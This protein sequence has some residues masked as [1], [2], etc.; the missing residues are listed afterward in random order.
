MSV[1]GQSIGSGIWH[2]LPMGY[3]HIL[4][5]L[6]LFFLKSE[7]RSALVQCSVFTA[8][9]SLTLGLAALGWISVA[10]VVVESAIAMS[11]V[12][13]AVEN[14]MGA[15][16]SP[17]RLLMVFVFGLFHGLGF[18]SAMKDSLQTQSEFL[19]RLFG[20]NL[21][22][23]LAQVIIILICALIVLPT[24]AQKTWYRSVIVRP[25]SLAIAVFATF[26]TVQRLLA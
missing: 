20:F 5:I 21:G 7:L 14:Y 6:C 25:L 18:A 8:A 11:I 12:V 19:V 15:T 13:V 2:V 1:L 26:L 23:E 9:H 22:V 4:F 17:A 3:D 24:L 16:K 10:S